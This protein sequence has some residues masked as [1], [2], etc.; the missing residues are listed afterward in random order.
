MKPQREITPGFYKH[1]KGGVYRVIGIGEHTETGEKLVVYHPAKGEKT[2]YIRPLEQF[3]GKV[4]KTKY[5]NTEQ[6]YRFIR[7][8]D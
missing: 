8:A 7:Y 4:D 5:P 1:F 2:L 6:L 3:A